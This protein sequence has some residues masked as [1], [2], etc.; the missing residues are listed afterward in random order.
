M[1]GEVISL[2]QLLFGPDALG[3]GRPD[4]VIYLRSS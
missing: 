3:E 4:L 2:K 1:M